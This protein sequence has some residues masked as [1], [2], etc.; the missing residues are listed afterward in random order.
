MPSFRVTVFEKIPVFRDSSGI[1]KNTENSECISEKY[2]QRSI[3]M[4][5]FIVMEKF[6]QKYRFSEFYRYSEKIPDI[7]IS[8]SNSMTKIALSL[9]VS[10]ILANFSV[11]APNLCRI[12]CVDLTDD[13]IGS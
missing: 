11:L 8:F 2:T 6:L 12:G 4:S 3:P 7:L 9:K 1:L 5:S 13:R 10:R